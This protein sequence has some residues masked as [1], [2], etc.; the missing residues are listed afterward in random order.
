MGRGSRTRAR[1]SLVAIKSGLVARPM[2]QLVERHIVKVVR[3]LEPSKC[4]HRDK[5][6]AWDVAGFAVALADVRAG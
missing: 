5:I 1:S 4:R 3:S 6:P 2:R